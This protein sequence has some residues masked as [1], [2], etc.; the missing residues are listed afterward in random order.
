[1]V[2][3]L[4]EGVLEG[5]WVGIHKDWESYNNI[6]TNLFRACV[7]AEDARFMQHGG[8]DWHAVKEA[9]K[10]N[11]LHKGKKKR[12]AS[13]ITMQTAKNTFLTHA[14]NYLRK[15]F[16]VYFTYLIEAIWGK[17]RILEIYVNVVEWGEGI[18]GAEEAS[19]MFFHK[20]ANNLTKHEAALLAAVLPNPIR[21]SPAKP[22][23]YILKRAAMIESRMPYV[24]I[25]KK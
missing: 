10:Y 15:G 8:I 3:R 9:E 7:A 4:G 6:S 1:M 22:T 5:K 2:F 14:R 19:Q 17:R 20:S 24:A 18:Y 25:P 23:A 12:G 21:W 16:E 11:E 13:T